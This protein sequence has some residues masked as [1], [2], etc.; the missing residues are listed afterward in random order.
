MTI[1]SCASRLN[2]AAWRLLLYAVVEMMVKL[3]T[4][5]RRSLGLCMGLSSEILF[6]QYAAGIGKVKKSV[7]KK[8][9]I[10]SHLIAYVSRFTFQVFCFRH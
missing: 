7:E 9:F 1:G 8:S 3:A 10:V 5:A 4:M 6:P 2:G